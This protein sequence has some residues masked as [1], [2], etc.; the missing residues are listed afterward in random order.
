MRTYG[1]FAQYEVVGF[2]TQISSSNYDPL[3]FSPND[4]FIPA[5][6]Q[7]SAVTRSYNFTFRVEGLGYESFRQALTPTLEASGARMTLRDTGWDEVEDTFFLLQDRRT[8]MLCSAGAAFCLAALL[9]AVLTCRNNR[10]AYGL[11][12]M[13]G[14]TRREAASSYLVP[15]ALSGLLG[16]VPAVFAAM[17]GYQLWMRPAMEEVLSV[18]LPTMG[19]CGMILVLV[20]LAQLVLSSLILLILCIVEEQRGLLRLI[21]R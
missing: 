6:S 14:A 1:E 7:D 9:F 2:Y 10:Y 15:F 3:F 20:S 21:R 5:T 12:R 17:T 16:L 19:E 18:T 13:L 8:V 11:R 4:I